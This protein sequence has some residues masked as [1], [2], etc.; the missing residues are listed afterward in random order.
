MIV[1][2]GIDPTMLAGANPD[3]GT[4]GD[5]LVVLDTP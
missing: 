4:V 2:Y 5:Q 1:R 3:L